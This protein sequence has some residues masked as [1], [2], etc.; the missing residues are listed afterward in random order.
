MLLLLLI[1]SNFIILFLIQLIPHAFICVNMYFGF[2]FLYGYKDRKKL[3]IGEK[4]IAEGKS[5]PQKSDCGMSR[6]K[7]FVKTRQ[8][9]RRTFKNKKP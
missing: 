8:H 2:S 1:F 5:F 7:T 6:K 9:N 4:R 3:Q